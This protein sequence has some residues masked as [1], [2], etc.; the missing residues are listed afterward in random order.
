[1]TTTDSVLSDSNRLNSDPSPVHSSPFHEGELAIQ[2]H[3]GVR[4][5][6]DPWARQVIHDSLPDQHREFYAQLPFVV[7]AARDQQ[8]EPWVTLLA[9]EP[10]FA[11]SPDPGE[12]ANP[13]SSSAKSAPHGHRNI[14]IYGENPGE[15][16]GVRG[17]G[18]GGLRTPSSEATG[19]TEAAIAAQ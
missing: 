3:M 12:L 15:P 14:F 11:S 7:V 2:E 13:A 10:G 8:G 16:S 6:M 1:M 18:D 5:E 9:G 17:L 4:A 19:S